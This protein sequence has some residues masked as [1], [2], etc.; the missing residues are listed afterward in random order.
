MQVII[1]PMLVTI[2]YFFNSPNHPPPK[3]LD[4]FLYKY[5]SPF[6]LKIF[7]TY[8]NLRLPSI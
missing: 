2:M 8:F 6:D 5:T 7:K 1:I 3:F 4:L